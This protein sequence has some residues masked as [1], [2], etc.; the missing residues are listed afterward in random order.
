MNQT[1]V[2]MSK[3][4]LSQALIELLAPNNRV[5]TLELK[6]H[7]RRTAPGFYWTQAVVSEMMN[8]LYERGVLTYTDNGTYR[9]YSLPVSEK[10]A[11]KTSDKKSI[12]KTKAIEL[13]ENNRGHFFTAVF[14]KKN[15]DDRKINCQYLKDQEAS[16]LG[17]IKVRELNKLK[18]KEQS[19]RQI[20][21]QTLKSLKINGVVYKVK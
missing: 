15:G 12:S 18:D 9:T 5:T 4:L 14:T 1:T 2:D 6:L 21:V 16:K 19:I 10:K 7:L 8:E 13:M 11:K 20:N 17:Y 3:A